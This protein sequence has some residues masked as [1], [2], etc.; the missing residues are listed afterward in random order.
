[1]I[2]PNTLYVFTGDF[3]IQCDAPFN[4]ACPS[5][6][7]TIGIPPALQVPGVLQLSDPALIAGFSVSQSPDPNGECM[8]GGGGSF[9]DGT[10]EIVSITSANVVFKLAGTNTSE[11]D[12]NGDHTAIRCP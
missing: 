1:M 2:D 5:W 7:V 4:S 3:A 11:F 10:I 8:S 6:H 9:L 12:A